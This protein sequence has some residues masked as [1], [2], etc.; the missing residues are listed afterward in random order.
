VYLNATV[1]SRM[2]SP[3]GSITP[4]AATTKDGRRD[5]SINDKSVVNPPE[6]QY[7]QL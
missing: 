3:I 6:Q 7:A 2:E 1:R 4:V 5:G